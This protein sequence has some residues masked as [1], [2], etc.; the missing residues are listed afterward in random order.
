VHAANIG[1]ASMGAYSGFLAT[2]L[3]SHANMAVASADCT[4]IAKSGHYADIT[5]FSEDL[6]VMNMV[7]IVDAMMAYDDPISHT[8]YLLVMRNALSIP[9]MGHNLIPTSL[10]RKA[11][12][13]LDEMQKFQLDTPTINNHAIVDDVTGMRI[14]LKLNGI[15]SYFTTHNLIQ[16]EMDN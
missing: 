8:T 2:E 11:G 7:E 13:A 6:P 12:L 14:H 10:I 5:H 16:E 1:G 4:I 9:S 15:F 3:D